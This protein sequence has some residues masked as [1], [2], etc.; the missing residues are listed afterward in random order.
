M[1]MFFYVFVAVLSVLA[2]GLCS[3]GLLVLGRVFVIAA[4]R[5][6]QIAQVRAPQSDPVPSVFDEDDEDPIEDHVNDA[7]ENVRALEAARRELS[8]LNDK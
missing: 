3:L 7:R 6:A 8:R 1:T 4:T 5:G 2:L